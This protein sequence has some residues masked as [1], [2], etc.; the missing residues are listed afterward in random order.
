MTD[1]WAAFWLSCGV[2]FVAELGDKSQLIAPTFATRYRP[3]LV[4]LDDEEATLA[5]PWPPRCL[6]A[7]YEAGTPTTQLAVIFYLSKGAVL[8]LLHEAGISMR[9]QPLTAQELA[10]ARRLDES[11]LSLVAVGE[12]IGRH[13]TTVHLSRAGLAS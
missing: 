8:M 7:E 1:L 6:L 3:V 13:H 2:V 12:R 10:D 9:R 5:S 11:G 4:D